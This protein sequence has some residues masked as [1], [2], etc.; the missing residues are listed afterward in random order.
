MEE[1]ERTFLVKSLP[2]GLDLGNAK[3][4]LD[5][6]LP[7]A[8]EHPHLRIRKSGSRYEITNKQPIQEEDASHQIENTI[9]LTKEEYD[10]LSS[11]QG[12]RVSKTRYTYEENGF[13]YEIDIFKEDL[14][15][16]ILADVEFSSIE[17]KNTFVP[18]PWCSADVTQEPYVAG[19]IL[20]GKSFK[21]IRSHLEKYGL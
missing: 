16:L 5:I 12:K 18:P 20:A 14:A 6:Y 3:E 4:M 10:E 8:S 11:V 19:G 21:K 1:L 7:S 17:D 15:G 9:P 13:V 2:E